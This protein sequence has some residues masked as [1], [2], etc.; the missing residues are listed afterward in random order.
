MLE[1]KPGKAVL[2]RI[3]HAGSLGVLTISTTCER[4][5]SSM[6]AVVSTGGSQVSPLTN[7]I[8]WISIRYLYLVSLSAPDIL[9]Y[10]W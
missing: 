8:C 9:V 1:K 6:S 10:R 4:T 5:I 3:G 7:I 2:V